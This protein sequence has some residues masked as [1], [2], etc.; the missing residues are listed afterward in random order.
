MPAH[1]P[2][3]VCRFWQTLLGVIVT[4]LPGADL[5]SSAGPKG[6]GQDARNKVRQGTP[7]RRLG[8]C[9]ETSDRCIALLPHI[10]VRIATNG[11]ENY[12][13]A[14]DPGACADYACA[15]NGH[16][17]GANSED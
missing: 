3:N 4:N 1:P 10:H 15:R 14:V 2:N 6:G 17:F 16:L 13:L 11:G 9:S 12:G 7:Y 5:N 8:N